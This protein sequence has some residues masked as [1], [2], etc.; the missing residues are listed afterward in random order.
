VVC[1]LPR[2][3]SVARAVIFGFAVGRNL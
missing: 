2:V 3:K 1:R